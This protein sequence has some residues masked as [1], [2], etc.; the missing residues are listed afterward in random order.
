MYTNRIRSGLLIW[1]QEGRR[2]FIGSYKDLRFTIII[3]QNSAILVIPEELGGQ[4]MCLPDEAAAMEA[5]ERY[6]TEDRGL[7]LVIS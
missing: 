5:A 6:C 7:R 3:K 4:E 1:E 2:S